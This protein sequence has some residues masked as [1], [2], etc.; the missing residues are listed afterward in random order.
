[1]TFR[2]LQRSLAFASAAVLFSGLALAQE[3]KKE[4]APAT[5]AAPAAP[6]PAPA[7]EATP[8]A[9]PA[10]APATEA[11]PAAAPVAVPAPK[12]AEAVAYGRIYVYREKRFMGAALHHDIFL[13]GKQVA[14]IGNGSYFILK[15]T[16]GAHKLRGEEEKEEV[17]VTVEAGKTYYFR[18]QIMPGFMKGHGKVN[19]VEEAAATKE[20]AEWLPKLKYCDDLKTPELFEKP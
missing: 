11:T 2:N 5:P 6:A 4:T 12:A 17:A 16:P 10:A 13:D 20:F 1:M 18:T 19:A 9:A 8:A 15:A 14:E 7:P 3:P